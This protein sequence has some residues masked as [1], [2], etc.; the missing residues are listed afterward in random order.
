MPS[1]TG[2]IIIVFVASAVI[3]LL[4]RNIANTI[5]DKG[6]DAIGN[7]RRKNQKGKTENLVDRYRFKK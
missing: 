1:E 6:T 4:V 7:R 5:I 2:I 3:Y